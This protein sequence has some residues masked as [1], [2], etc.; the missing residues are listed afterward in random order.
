MP[1]LLGGREID[2]PSAGANTNEL[3]AKHA[4]Y[5]EK[6]IIGKAFCA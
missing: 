1:E 3:I 6:K 4:W 2:L 5:V